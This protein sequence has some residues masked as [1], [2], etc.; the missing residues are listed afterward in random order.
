MA[1]KHGFWPGVR[2]RAKSDGATGSVTR[3][4]KWYVHVWLDEEDREVAY[5]ADVDANM[6]LVREG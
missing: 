4:N 5:F 3:I 1:A 2:V 6:F